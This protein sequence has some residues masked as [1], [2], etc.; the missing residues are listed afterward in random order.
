MFRKRVAGIPRQRL[1]V[2]LLGQLHALHLEWHLPRRTQLPAMLLVRSR[3]LAQPVVHVRAETRAPSRTAASSRH[4][5]S[6]PP[7]SI[8]SRG[9]SG[10]TSPLA[11]AASSTPGLID[12]HRGPAQLDRLVEPLHLGLADAEEGQVLALRDPVD[13]RVGGKHLAATSTRHHAR[14]EVDLAAEVV[15]VAVEGGPVVD[16]DA[17]LRALTEEML[18]AHRPVGQGLHVLAD[19]HHLVADRLD[20]ARVVRQRLDDRLDESLDK[21]QRLLLADLLREARVAREVAKAITTCRR[22]SRPPRPS[23]S[24]C[25]PPRPARRSAAGSAG[26]RSP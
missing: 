8:T 17:R 13:H 2:A 25:G 23:P 20:H 22:P 6:A 15:A 1:D 11:R 24:P 26:A 4:T 21:R 9:R 5:E 7:E 19:D 12:G 16:A 14:G 10:T 18:K 3:L